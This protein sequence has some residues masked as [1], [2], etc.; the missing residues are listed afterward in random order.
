MQFSEWN[1]NSNKIYQT[2]FRTLDAQSQLFCMQCVPKG[3]VRLNIP[4][5]AALCNVQSVC[6]NKVLF[7]KKK[8]KSHLWKFKLIEKRRK[9]ERD[10]CCQETEC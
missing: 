8:V 5:T 3:T 7:W 9:I 4:R 10:G 2:N 1:I 6:V